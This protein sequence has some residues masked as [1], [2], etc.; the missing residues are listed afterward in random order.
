[1]HKPHCTVHC[2]VENFNVN[3]AN[4]DSKSER[5]RTV[6]CAEYHVQERN[7]PD[8]GTATARG[9]STRMRLAV[10]LSDPIQF[11]T[12]INGQMSVVFCSSPENLNLSTRQRSR[13]GSYSSLCLR[14]RCDG[15]L[16][17]STNLSKPYRQFLHW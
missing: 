9:R 11:V 5:Y 14:F 13:N 7:V 8:H 1:M 4:L 12:S 16:R 2:T 10:A 15:R 3:F 17:L 6:L